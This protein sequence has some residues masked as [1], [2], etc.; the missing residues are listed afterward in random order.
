MA[1]GINL[2]PL[3]FRKSYAK[4]SWVRLLVFKNGISYGTVTFLARLKM[5]A[6][7]KYLMKFCL[8]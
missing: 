6:D 3:S 1:I 4:W 5:G 8:E 2:N 7:D